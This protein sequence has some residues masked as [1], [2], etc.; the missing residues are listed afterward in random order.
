MVSKDEDGVDN[1]NTFCF[2]HEVGI[3]NID[4]HSRTLI[5]TR[6]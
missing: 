3:E 4:T 2:G 1:E 5:L 6:L